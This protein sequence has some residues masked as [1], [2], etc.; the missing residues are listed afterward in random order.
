MSVACETLVQPPSSLAR[1]T[2]ATTPFAISE[3]HNW[4]HS[5]KSEKTADKTV[6]PTIV[7][8]EV[9]VGRKRQRRLVRAPR[10]MGQCSR[11][12]VVVICDNPRV[13]VLGPYRECS[14]SVPGGW[15]GKTNKNKNHSDPA[16]NHSV[17]VSLSSTANPKAGE[18][19]HGDGMG[20]ASKQTRTPRL[21]NVDCKRSRLRRN[22]LCPQSRGRSKL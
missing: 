21:L 22:R 3:K 20:H 11:Q 5:R 19:R 8:V 4:E 16:T 7:V 12:G 14:E 17:N 10:T 13:C 15:V 9:G 6:G 18:K 1:A 2:A